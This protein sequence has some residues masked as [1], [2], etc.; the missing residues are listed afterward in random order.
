MTAAPTPRRWPRA[1][2]FVLSRTGLEVEASY[3][4]HVQ[5]S[6]AVEGRASYDAARAAWAGEHRLDPDDGL[7]LGEIRSGPASLADMVES[8]DAC[9]KNHRDAL[10]ALDRLVQRGLVE[11]LV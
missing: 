8:L 2:K 5:G 3:R 9:G 6:R 11:A 4:A 10:S 1:Q 7:Y